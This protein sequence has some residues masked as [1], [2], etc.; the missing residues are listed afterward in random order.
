[1][2]KV[3]SLKTVQK[4]PVSLATAWDFFSSPANLKHIT[5]NNLG[6]NIVSKH[7]GNKM[8]AG[9]IIEYT[10][11]PLLGIPMY[12]MTEIT[13]VQPEQF[14][15]DEQR[16]GPYSMWHHQHHFV[17]IDGGVEM[18]DIVH[19]KMPLWFLG[20]IANTILVKEQLRKIFNHRFVAVE[21]HFGKWQ[22]ANNEII[23]G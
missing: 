10:V 14:F 23:F 5:P 16:F 1:M 11:S 6:F 17:A 8:Y 20:D 12:W 21:Q 4:I 22:N 2:S 9:Q 3:Y 7:H 18:T 19:Y 15:V 13:H